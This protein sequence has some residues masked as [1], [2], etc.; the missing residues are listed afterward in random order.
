[1]QRIT[2]KSN[3][4]LKYSYKAM[5]AHCKEVRNVDLEI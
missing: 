1:M 5:V 3:E 4:M 2:I